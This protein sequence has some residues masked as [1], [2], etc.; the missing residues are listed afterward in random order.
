MSIKGTI[1][2]ELRKHTGDW[3]SG[4][5][6]SD[7]LNVTRSAVW[8]QIKILREEGYPIE[9]LPKKGYRFLGP[10]DLLLPEE[11]TAGLKT[12]VF[13]QKQNFY[14]KEIGSTNMEA[15]HLAEM[16]YPEGTI[17]LAEKQTEGRGRR[18]RS[19]YSP[20]GEGIYVSLLLRPK[21][22][23]NEAPKIPL[24]TAVAVAAALKS[25]IENLPL[26]I[27][28]PNDILVNGKK[29][30][31]ILA[32]VST[33]MEVINYVIVGIGLNVN[34]PGESF[35]PELREIATSILIATG[36]SCLRIRILQNI[37]ESFEKYYSFLQEGNFG[38]VL[39]KLDEFSVIKGA[40]VR[41]DTAKGSIT[42]KVLD[43]DDDGFLIVRDYNGTIHRVL[44][45]DV[46]IIPPEENH[47][48]TMK[49]LSY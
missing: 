24:V 34:T 30:G 44:S 8:K 47:P 22:V 40:S 49:S 19:W 4:E 7:T 31:G 2:T 18:G 32:E 37:L 38:R 9:S 35:P 10:P 13:G 15:R 14:F 36:K 1:L 23:S 20:S 25:W 41:L 12:K 48:G 27:K 42:G 39:Q 28:W 5:L 43:I 46:S 17:V 21:I 6:L 33:D 26:Q 11:I 16:G 29:L 45:G 3:V